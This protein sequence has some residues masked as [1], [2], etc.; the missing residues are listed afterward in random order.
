M[1]IHITNEPHICNSDI[2]LWLRLID[3]CLASKATRALARVFPRCL[4]LNPKA[5]SVWIKAA[6]WEF[7][8]NGNIDGR[9][10]GHF[11]FALSFTI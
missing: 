11:V 9:K 2:S 7:E 8:S 10:S 3:F 4:Q 1:P 6:A 5:V